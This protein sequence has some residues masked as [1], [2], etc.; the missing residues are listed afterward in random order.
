MTRYDWVPGWY[1]A[2][3]HTLP[4]GQGVAWR[5]GELFIQSLAPKW[6]DMTECQGDTG[7]WGTPCLGGQGV[8]WRWGELFIQSLA[9]KWQDMTEC[10][11]DTGHWG[12]PRLGGQGVAWRWGELFIQS[13]APKWK[14]VAGNGMRVLV[15]S[16]WRSLSFALQ[17]FH[18]STSI[19]VMISHAE[20]LTRHLEILQEDLGELRYGTRT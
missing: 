7:H 12:T 13:L 17:E 8:A 6:Q 19:E 4:R 9:P 18:M 11:G 2:L 1:R 16:G 15:G 20:N 10:Q 3:G 14:G 5:W